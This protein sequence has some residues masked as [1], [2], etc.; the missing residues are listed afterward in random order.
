MK[1]LLVPTDFSSCANKAAQVALELAKKLEAEVHFLHFTAIP[2]DWVNLENHQEKMYPDITK[3]VRNRQ[4]K[5]NELVQK[6]ER[7]G[8]PA[9]SYI[10]YNEGY[11]NVISYVEDH[12]ID[13]VIMGSHGASGLKEIFLGSNAQKIIRLSD[14]PV[15]VVKEDT[16]HFNALKMV[17]VSDF[18]GELNQDFDDVAQQGFKK[19]LEMAEKLELS[20][21]LLY[22]NTPANF[23]SSK[24]ML[25]RMADYESIAED[26]IASSTIINANSIERG[27]KDYL[28]GDDESIVAMMTHG[29]QGFS[30]WV[31][32][33]KVEA[34]ANHLSSPFLSIKMQEVPE[35]EEVD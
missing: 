18:L 5:L 13:L 33:S 1:K 24:V 16:P 20:V 21:H 9:Y 2:I 14:I 26:T 4:Q 8:L 25:S 7:M 22:V 34:I 27:I 3:K 15:L 6:A 11:S 19:L 10:G 35:L 30:R 31:S 28:G 12:Q 23:I 17:V 32:G 29:E